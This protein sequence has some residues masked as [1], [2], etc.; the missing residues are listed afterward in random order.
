V[1][2]AGED[3]T[4]R[5][6]ESGAADELTVIA[7]HPGLTAFA[8]DEDRRRIA[9]G[10]ERGAVEVLASDG[11]RTS[12]TKIGRPIAGV[13]F[14]TAGARAVTSP[15]LSIAISR[16]GDVARGTRNGTVSLTDK[17]GHTRLLHSS[18]AVTAVAFSP[19]RRLLAT[20][21]SAG[22]V[23]LWDARTG[24]REKRFVAHKLAVNSIR[25][26]PDGRLLLTASSDHEARLWD[27]ETARLLH[28]LGLHFG[29]VSSASFSPDGRWVVTAGCCGASVI[30]TSTGQRWLILRGHSKPLIGA[31]F[32]GADGHLIVTAGRDG[33]VRSYRCDVCADV[34]GLI[35]SAERRLRRG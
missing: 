6:W 18:G 2:T 19:D 30:S 26:S 32:A 33:T 10:D 8:V 25:F 31:E 21:S 3:G 23:T 20:G 29:P 22:A 27:V 7:N 34:D 11:S 12:T 16:E 5:L 9:V 24:E 17:Q 1:A 13:A 4:A 35:L 14:A 28:V 15:D